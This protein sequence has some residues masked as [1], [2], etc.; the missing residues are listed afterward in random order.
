MGF[1]GVL[2]AF[3]PRYFGVYIQLWHPLIENKFNEYTHS[4]VQNA[5][6]LKS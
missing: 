6:K 2:I 5:K 3:T 1:I 4:F